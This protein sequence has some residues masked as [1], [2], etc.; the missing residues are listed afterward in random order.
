[1]SYPF[2][3][4]LVYKAACGDEKCY[5]QFLKIWKINQIF[6]HWTQYPCNHEPPCTKPTDNQI[7]V[8]NDRL[9]K[10]LED[11]KDFQNE[12]KEAGIRAKKDKNEI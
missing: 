10:D 9:K 1:M 2:R 5:Q 11:D 7:A 4:C 8:F 3:V 12:Y 6:G